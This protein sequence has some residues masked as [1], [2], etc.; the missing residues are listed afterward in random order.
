M[1]RARIVAITVRSRAATKTAASAA[2]RMAR[3][4]GGNA[5]GRVVSSRACGGAGRAGDVSSTGN[6]PPG[7]AAARGVGAGRATGYCGRAIVTG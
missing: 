4:P 5:S 3:A 6:L 1:I 2:A 7:R